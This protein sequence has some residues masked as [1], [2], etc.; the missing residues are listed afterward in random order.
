MYLSRVR[1]PI[2]RGAASSFQSV[3]GPDDI[4]VPARIAG[5]HNVDAEPLKSRIP[6]QRAPRRRR[7]HIKRVVVIEAINACAA[8]LGHRVLSGSSSSVGVIEFH[9]DASA[10]ATSYERRVIDVNIRTAGAGMRPAQARCPAQLKF[11]WSAKRRLVRFTPRLHAQQLKRPVA[12]RLP[13]VC[14]SPGPRAPVLISST[15]DVVPHVKMP[16]KVD[17]CLT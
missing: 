11:L 14:G 1:M 7:S 10:F 13:P 4:V 8:L 6:L 17:Q 16:A 12:I 9:R 3:G 15:R 2:C 5:R